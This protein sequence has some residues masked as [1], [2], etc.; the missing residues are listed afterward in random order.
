LTVVFNDPKTKD[1]DKNEATCKN[2]KSS[3]RES[4]KSMSSQGEIGYPIMEESSEL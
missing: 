3:I 2:E 4:I 1:L